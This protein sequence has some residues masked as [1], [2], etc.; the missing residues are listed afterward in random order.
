MWSRSECN[1]STLKSTHF[2]ANSELSEPA[3]TFFEH[4]G[5]TS[6]DVGMILNYEAAPGKD[7]RVWRVMR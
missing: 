1:R 2:H 5:R 4:M 6:F 7:L 3:E